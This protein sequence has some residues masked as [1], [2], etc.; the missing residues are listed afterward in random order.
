MEPT[1][2]QALVVAKALE[3]YARTGIKV[4]RAYT[5]SGMMRTAGQLTGRTFKPRDYV[6]AAQ[7]LREW[8]FQQQN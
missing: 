3:L 6:G 7:V 1:V 5:P 2:Y 8:A 4:N